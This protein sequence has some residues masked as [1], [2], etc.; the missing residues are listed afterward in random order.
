MPY[1]ANMEEL[2]WTSDSG[3]RTLLTRESARRYN[4]PLRNTRKISCFMT[5]KAGPRLGEGNDGVLPDTGVKSEKTHWR[6]YAL[7]RKDEA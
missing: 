6:N 1:A 3:P 5:V 4:M 2:A 7:K